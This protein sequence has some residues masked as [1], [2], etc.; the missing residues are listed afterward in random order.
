[1]ETESGPIEEG[2]KNLLTSVHM[3]CFSKTAT[4]AIFDHKKGE[5][6]LEELKVELV[7]E[8]LRRYKSNLLRHITRMN[9]NRMPKVILN[10]MYR[11]N[12]RRRSGRPLKRLLDEVETF[13]PKSNS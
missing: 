9:N 7:D 13:L 3:K 10:Y 11:I 6:F 4:Y 1:M 5:E 12:R 2:I 8:K